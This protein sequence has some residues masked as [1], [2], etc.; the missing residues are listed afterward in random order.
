M[1][2]W[3]TKADREVEEVGRQQTATSTWGYD[4]GYDQASSRFERSNG[5]SSGFCKCSL[6]FRS[7]IESPRSLRYCLLLL[8]FVLS[9]WTLI[10]SPPDGSDSSRCVQTICDLDGPDNLSESFVPLDFSNDPWKCN[11]WKERA[12]LVECL[13]A[14]FARLRHEIMRSPLIPGEERICTL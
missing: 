3:Y 5:S 9:E 7:S 8:F 11:I 13:L 14:I 1:T 4:R 6:H 2:R 12:K 10:F